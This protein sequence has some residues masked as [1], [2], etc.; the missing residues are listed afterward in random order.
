LNIVEIYCKKA[1]FVNNH[2][3]VVEFKIRVGGE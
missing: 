1:E 3:I 2:E